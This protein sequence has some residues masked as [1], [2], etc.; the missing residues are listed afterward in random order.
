V[1]YGDGNGATVGDTLA[2]HLRRAGHTVALARIRAG[3][4]QAADVAAARQALAAGGTPLFAIAVR[5]TSGQA[6]LAVPEPVA[7][8]MTQTAGRTPAI[9]VSFG[10]PY[11][12]SQAPTA[13]A[14]LAAWTT[15]SLTERAVAEALSGGAIT[16]RL[17][18]P[19][20]PG[21]PLGT[22]L[23]RPAR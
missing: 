3:T 2:D 21:I 10:S 23:Q 16:G 12:V 7:A 13:Q 1:A 15:N 20:P 14:F 11:V 5:V 18:I 8:L 6:R 4:T 19:I 9:L 17:P 22:G